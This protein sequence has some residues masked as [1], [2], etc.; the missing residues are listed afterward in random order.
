MHIGVIMHKQ[1]GMQCMFGIIEVVNLGG[2]T[3]LKL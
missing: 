2:A 1:D 3:K